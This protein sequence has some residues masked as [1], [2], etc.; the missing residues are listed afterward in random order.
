MTSM[1]PG[2]NNRI[3]TK[4]LVRP[5]WAYKDAGGTSTDLTP[6]GIATTIHPQ[7]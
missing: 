6:T 1:T 4:I 3:H 7:P 2:T 5:R